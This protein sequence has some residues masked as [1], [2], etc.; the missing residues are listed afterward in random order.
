M[1]FVHLHTH[2]HYT[3]GRG[4]ASVRELV[5]RAA[6]LGMPAVALTD[7]NTIVGFEELID[8]A[9]TC[10]IQP[11]LGCELH[12]LPLQHTLYQGHTHPITLLVRTDQGYRNLVRLL[13]LAHSAPDGEPPHVKASQLETHARGLI[14]L[15]GPAEGELCHLLRSGDTEATTAYL[16]R[17]A[18]T[19]EP[20]AVFFEVIEYPDPAL[21]R[22]M[23]Y[24]LELSDF[25]NIPAVAT[26]DV[27]FLDPADMP[28]Y[29]AIEQQPRL[30]APQWP[31]PDDQ[32]P[33][34]HF[35]TER[36]MRRRFG[37]RPAVIDQ[38]VALAEMCEF[39]FPRGRSRIPLHTFDR[40]EDPPSMLWDRAVRGA[41]ARYGGLTEEVKQR[42]NAE[43]RCL[44]GETD[45]SHGAP[46]LLDLAEYLLFAQDIMRFVREE[47]MSRGIGRGPLL[48]SVLAYCLGITDA[49]P[50]A[51]KLEFQDP[52]P[53][54]DCL[55]P[56]DI[57]LSSEGSR[58]L[59]EH[60][61][62]TCGPRHVVHTAHRIDWDRNRLF[63]QLC[64]WAGLGPARLAD[65]APDRRTCKIDNE[66][67]P[68]LVGEVREPES[69]AVPEADGERP[70]MGENR[71]PRGESLR[72][73]RSL[74]AIVYRLH[75]LPRRFE[76]ERTDVV[77]SRDP[78]DS[79]VPL[80]EAGPQPFC[81]GGRDLV[82]RLE[83]PRIRLGFSSAIN[84]LE[85]AASWVRMEEDPHFSINAV[86]LDDADT[87][88]L[89]GLGLTNGVGPFH[90][91]TMK[92]I[93]RSRRPADTEALLETCAEN[94]RPG[95]G[96]EAP[97]RVDLLP[98]CILGYRCAY[99][100]VHH[101]VS[102]MTAMLTHSISR[103][104]G[105]TR[106]PSFQI[107]L[108]EARKMG[109]EVLGPD[110][111]LSSAEFSQERR[112][113]RT[114]LM[115]VQGLG[116][117]TFEEIKR[118][119]AGVSFSS[120]EDFC[121]RTDPR[122]VSQTVVRRLIKAGAFD[123]I[124]PNRTRL[125]FDFER[126]LKN[127]RPSHRPGA[128]SEDEKQLQL[129]EPDIFD[130]THEAELAPPGDAPEPSPEDIVRYEREAMG[131]AVTH[132]MLEHYRSLTA[133]MA[134]VSPFEM[135]RYAADGKKSE[136]RTI[137]VVGFV[138]H[139]EHE[140]PLVREAGEA[141][142]DLEGH[143]LKAPADL[144][145]PIDRIQKSQSPVLVMGEVQPRGR[146]ECFL[147]RG[148]SICS[149]TSPASRARWPSCASISPVSLT[150]S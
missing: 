45:A 50:I 25:L 54:P 101:P 108:R 14:A 58:R 113:I 134:A 11:I 126:L 148:A 20:G 28:A 141:V 119:H 15:T 81:Q 111:N 16:N 118:A 8:E 94:R 143:V 47:R 26:Q 83:L 41:S 40:G 90:S 36:E 65:Y 125:L 136:P 23:D 33:T 42:L 52:R 92:S 24:V 102:F 7:T 63:E 133:A 43:Y 12:V 150:T 147:S 120:L 123:N 114:G 37:F 21:R 86:P 17:L 99:M 122:L 74:A 84:V 49:D 130:A 51:H 70:L 116:E 135:H 57:E 71:I 100:K 89:L 98:E 149:K 6:R 138:D 56:L 10:E 64:R 115:A 44:R 61:R 128:D 29:C 144:K 131:H 59:I 127:A 129:F 39:R 69:P 66:L 27:C 53:A 79:V 9:R 93:L 104:D 75:P 3:I 1:G 139:V 109:F 38:T 124:E 68:D 62:E 46:A 95:P 13:T 80:I 18:G 85:R 32:M 22:V 117:K 87:F 142:L 5:R 82:D 91:I 137:F 110:I 31:L 107:I 88:R 105:P 34:R 76:A 19:F 145:A 35:T 140:G 146:N 67:T 112:R 132:D 30:L 73:H 4:V 78:L 96:E 48:T 77:M 103:D 121:Q 2:S 72:E 55:P 97:G 60:L 106:R